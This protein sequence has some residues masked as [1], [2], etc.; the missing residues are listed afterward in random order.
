MKLDLNGFE[1]DML[2][3]SLQQS[4][5]YNEKVAYKVAK[6]PGYHSDPKEGVKTLNRD[7]ATMK[8]III[9]LQVSA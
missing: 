8:S 3:A 7:N 9:K 2:L 6:Y 1:V 4:I 5:A